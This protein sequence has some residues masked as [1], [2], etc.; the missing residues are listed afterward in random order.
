[1]KLSEHFDSREFDCKGDGIDC[2]CGGRGKHMNPLLIILLEQLREN[3]GG[4]PLIITSGYRCSRH[5]RN[6]GG[7]EHSQHLLWNA[8]DVMCPFELSYSE[9]YHE[10]CCCRLGTL[11]FDGVGYYPSSNFVHVDVRYNGYGPLVEF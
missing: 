4:Y 6:V 10:V 5:N 1:M 2:H 9:F 7:A 11:G 3:I 8:A